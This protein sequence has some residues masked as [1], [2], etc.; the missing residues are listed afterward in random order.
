MRRLFILGLILLLSG[1]AY[2]S[3]NLLRISG[4]NM[5]F[6]YG[7]IAAKGVKSITI[8]RE[9]NA[10]RGKVKNNLKEIRDYLHAE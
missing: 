5:D 7:L 3:R 6:S 9:T 10:G 1:C 8:L 4:D 2:N